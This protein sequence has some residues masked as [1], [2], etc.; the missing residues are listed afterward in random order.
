MR[1]LAP[2]ALLPVFL[3]AACSHNE[4]AAPQE[5]AQTVPDRSGL[6][7]EQAAAARMLPAARTSAA[8]ASNEAS[9]AAAPSDGFPS[10]LSTAEGA[11]C[12]LARAFIKADSAM[13]RRTCMPDNFIKS[14]DYK[15]FLDELAAVMD[16][17]KAGK[18]ANTG[19]PTEIKKLYKARSLS[20]NGPASAGYALFDFQA[21][22]FV[23]VE[24]ELTDGSMYTNRTLVFQLG[25][26]TW[27]VM[28][29]P[30]LVPLLSMGLNGESDSKEEWKPA[31]P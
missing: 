5:P 28:P 19:G 11:A 1:S 23:D 2:L 9:N 26:K 7:P 3:F 29:R 4:Q 24:T 27:R 6:T 21:V 8:A 30:D 20:K 16:D 10:G 15:A 25:D 12:D 17:I 18:A 31:K 13:F 22:Q 14:D